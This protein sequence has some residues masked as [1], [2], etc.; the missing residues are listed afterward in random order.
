MPVILDVDYSNSHH[1]VVAMGYDDRLGV[2]MVADPMTHAPRR[3][4]K[5]ADGSFSTA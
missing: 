1:V 2:L 5:G 3:Q 4:G